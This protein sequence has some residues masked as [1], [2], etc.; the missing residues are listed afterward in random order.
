[1]IDPARIGIVVIGRN[2]GQR[3]AACL[4]S[5]PNGHAVVYVDSASTDASVSIAERAGIE[6]VRLSS[7]EPLSAARARNTGIALL[8]NGASRPD[9][10][11]TL[12]GDCTLDSAWL[13]T[14]AALLDTD[15]GVAVV[16]GRLHERHPEK[17]AY[18]RLCDDEW[19]APAGEAAEC[20]GVA[21]W[22]ADAI[23][24]AG[25]FDATLNA[26]EEPELC[27]RLRRAGHRVW[28]LKAA[29]G[30]HDANLLKFTQWA[31]RMFR[32]GFSFAEL[33][34]RWAANSAPH[35]R[36][37]FVRII[38]WAF[39]VPVVVL[40][41]VLTGIFWLSL[42]GVAAWMLLLGKMTLRTWRSGQRPSWAAKSSALNLVGKFCQMGGVFRYLVDRQMRGVRG[43]YVYDKR[44]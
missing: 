26:G 25:L 30:T 5:L 32:S 27:H 8:R 39:V 40:C 4:A 1:M 19:D 29:M 20:G 17:S 34:G 10:I 16:A 13:A 15:A 21:L 41:G 6:A 44:V 2:E 18:N 24:A 35:W 11:Q 12:D 14:G 36:R 33:L 7:A 43:Q 22:R 9:Y 3:L 23:E 37:E 42:L 38:V 31:R 28:R